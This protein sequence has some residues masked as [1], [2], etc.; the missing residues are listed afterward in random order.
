MVRLGTRLGQGSTGTSMGTR[1]PDC[2]VGKGRR[3]TTPLDSSNATML[4]EPKLNMHIMIN[5]EKLLMIGVKKTNKITVY[6]SPM[7]VVPVL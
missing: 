2:W 5:C 3:A 1:L 6:D 4:H 7:K